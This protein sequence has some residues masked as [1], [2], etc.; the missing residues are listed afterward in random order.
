MATAADFGLTKNANG[1]IGKVREDIDILRHDVG[2]LARK[3][4]SDAKDRIEDTADHVQT[5]AVDAF[6]Q[7]QEQIRAKPGVALG[8]AAATG[9]VLGLLMSSRR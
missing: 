7:L 2:D 4:T 3:V 5:R 6:S 1:S 9:V 8:A